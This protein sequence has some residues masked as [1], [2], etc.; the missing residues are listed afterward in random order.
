MNK[1]LL[2]FFL[3]I[4]LFSSCISTKKNCNSGKKIKS[5]MW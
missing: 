1:L 5:E 3:G 4:F 2:L